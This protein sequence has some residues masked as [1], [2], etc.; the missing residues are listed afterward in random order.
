MNIEPI[1][2]FSNAYEW[3]ERVQEMPPLIIT[4]AINGG[5]QGKEANPAIPESP[6]E[7]AASTRDAYNAGASVAHIHARNPA[8][9]YENTCSSEVYLAI[10]AKVRSLCPEI[11]INNSTGG[12]LT[13][14][15]EE[16]FDVLKARPELASLNVGPDMVRMKL[17]PR[18]KPF[19][20]EHEALSFDE[21]TPYTYGF[22][23]EL[24][25]RMNAAGVKPEM[26]L[27]HPG[28]Y[29]VTRELI[30][31]GMIKPPYLFQFVMGYQTSSFP[32]PENLINLV[33]QLP[34]NARFSVIGIG[35]YQW[36]MTTMGII[37]GG[38]VR[39]GLEDNVYEGR[40]KL[41]ASNARAVEKITGIAKELGRR[42]ATPTEARELL[43][44]S[45]KPSQY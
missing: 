8:C 17:K 28:Q 6:E 2:D 44:L 21:C 43:G 7:I 11:V 33:N 25:S 15:I 26:E 29:W 14:R 1:K 27:Y 16:R 4:A 38:N 5:V 23:D 10:N 3:L 45:L 30:R 13:T 36:L 18:G 37:L 22:I 24:V 39:V 35:M 12:G 19:L 31:K 20:H 32:T 9:L 34:P 41:L 40:G 42:I